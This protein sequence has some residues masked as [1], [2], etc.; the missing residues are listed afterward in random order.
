MGNILFTL[1]VEISRGSGTERLVIITKH[2]RRFEGR[3][4]SG[5]DIVQMHLGREGV[6]RVACPALRT[7]TASR[8]SGLSWDVKAASPFIPPSPLQEKRGMSKGED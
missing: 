7:A 8:G 4:C 6:T 3:P 1:Q 2:H 5:Q